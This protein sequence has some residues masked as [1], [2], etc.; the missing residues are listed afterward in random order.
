LSKI[1]EATCDATG[2][3]HAEGVPVPAAEV[4]SKGAASSE[5]LLFLEEKK[6]KYLP[7]S[8]DD[9]ESTIQ[10]VIDALD[11]IGPALTEIASALT[12]IGAKMTGPTTSPP[13]TLPTSVATIASKVILI[14]TAK[15]QLTTLKGALK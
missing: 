13:P 4:L 8:A 5:G 12:A 15:T 3:V 2:L 10:D 7:S 11:A 6:A 9:I 1:L 14:S